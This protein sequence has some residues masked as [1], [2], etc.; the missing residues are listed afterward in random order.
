MKKID[1][2][3]LYTLPDCP[4]CER[5]KTFMAHK[6]IEVEQRDTSDPKNAEDLVRIGGSRQCPCLVHDGEALYES[7]DIMEYLLSVM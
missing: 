1:G 3:I 4:F 2:V 5:V 6:D 7:D